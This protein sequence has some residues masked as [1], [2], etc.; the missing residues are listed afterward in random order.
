MRIALTAALAG[1][2]TAALAGMAGP[3][4]AVTPAPPRT[5]ES[6]KAQVDAK[7]E[8][9]T[10]KMQALQTRLASRPKLAAAKTALEADISKTLADTDTWRKQVDAATTK[11]GIRAADPAHQAVKAD[12]AK[13]HSDLAN[14]KGAKNAA[15]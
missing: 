10:S 7:A 4:F 8:H 14:A 1:A 13:L 5:V 11:A 6:L 9:I 12:L 15:N 3:A 2:A